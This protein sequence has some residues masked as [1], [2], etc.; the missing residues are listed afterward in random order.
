MRVSGHPPRSEN[1]D[2]EFIQP[3]VID[4]ASIAEPVDRILRMVGIRID[5]HNGADLSMGFLAIPY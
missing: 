3:G 2:S 5:C 1:S 4:E